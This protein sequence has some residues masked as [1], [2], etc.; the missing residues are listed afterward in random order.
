MQLYVH[1]FQE[2]EP[3]LFRVSLI[4]I[5]DTHREN[6]ILLSLVQTWRYKNLMKKM[7]GCFWPFSYVYAIDEVLYIPLSHVEEYRCLNK[8][9][10]QIHS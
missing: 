9:I 3:L 1:S 5:N 10:H 6:L 7:L 2:F 4:L 8:V